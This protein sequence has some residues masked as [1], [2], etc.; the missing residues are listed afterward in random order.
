MSPLKFAII[1][2]RKREVIGLLNCCIAFM[3]LPLFVC[4]LVYL[5]HGA[6]CWSVFC[7][8][9]NSWL[10]L[11]ILCASINLNFVVISEYVFAGKKY[12][13]GL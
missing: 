6:T 9:G 13:R 2:L 5:L 3:C 4:C 10:Y 8:Y 7:D 11:P 12:T 1:L